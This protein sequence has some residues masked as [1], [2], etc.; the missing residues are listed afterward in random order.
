MPH[1]YSV[2]PKSDLQTENNIRVLNRTLDNHIYV[3]RLNHTLFHDDVTKT[4]STKAS[5]AGRSYTSFPNAVDVRARATL[6]RDLEWKSG[7]IR[8]K[9]I[10]YT[11]S[12]TGNNVYGDEFALTAYNSTTISSIYTSGNIAL[13][14]PGATTIGQLTK[15]DL[16]SR[17]DLTIKMNTQVDKLMVSVNRD[18]GHANDTNTGA[19]Q[20]EWVDLEYIELNHDIADD[21]TKSV[22]Y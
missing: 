3:V 6:P 19:W 5:D 16:S 7:V 12:V 13:T 14:L 2:T 20:L 21:F 18:G 9:S 17:N 1:N 4:G 11:T 8:M 15:L 10:W 22:V